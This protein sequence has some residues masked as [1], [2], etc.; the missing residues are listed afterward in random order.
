MGDGG[1][2][3]YSYLAS[4][5]LQGEIL[6]NGSVFWQYGFDAF[7]ESINEILLVDEEIWASTVG[8]G[9]FSFNLTQ[10]SFQPTPIS[11]QSDGR[12]SH[13]WRADVCGLDGLGRQLCWFPVLRS[14]SRTWGQGSLLA[15]LPSNIV[16]DFV[17]FGEHVLISTH[18]GI[19][20]WNQT[21]Y[22]WDDPIT[23]VDGLPTPISNHLFV[24]PSPVLGNGS[25]L[26]GGP[27]GMIVLDQNLGM[28]GSIGRADGLVGDFVSGIVYADSVSREVNDTSTG[29]MVTIHHDAALFISHN[30]QG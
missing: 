26:V 13:G 8:N 25:V 4:T 23:T 7:T 24:P 18:G 11:P 29:S 30:G 2:S 5:V 17:Q 6:D 14:G 16:T 12:A 15:G 9:L 10:R 28:V 3:E 21:K 22:D 27:T 20:L 19:G 1:S